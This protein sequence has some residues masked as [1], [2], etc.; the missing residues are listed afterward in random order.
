MN[1]GEKHI[2]IVSFDVP[3]PANYGGVIDVFYKVKA[4]SELGIQI[5]LHCFQYG[6]AAAEELEK[7]CC[8]VHYYKRLT[9]WHQHIASL[10]Y[11]V[12]SR[13]SIALLD[14]LQKDDYPILFEG[15]HTTFLLPHQALINREK[16][17]RMH[18]IEWRYY[19]NLFKISKNII[20]KAYYGIEAIKLRGYEK[21]IKFS[22]TTLAISPTDFKY[23]EDRFRIGISYLPAFHANENVS[24]PAGLGEYAFYH[25]NLGI[26]ENEEAALFLVNKVF[27]KISIPLVIAG[28][29][30][31]KSLKKAIVNNPN[32]SLKP[33]VSDKELFDL[34][35]GAQLNVLLAMKPSTGIKLKL[36]NVLFNG[37]HCIAN[38][39]LVDNTGLEEHCIIRNTATEIKH[40]IEHYFKRPLDD[41]AIASRK[42]DLDRDFSNKNNAKLLLEQ[43]LDF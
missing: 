32:I 28:L 8:E 31:S 25:A 30:P 21:I 19:N 17:I 43:M 18:N 42:K 33:N 14:N 29:N 10:P 9:S 26:K 15:L 35:K 34:I 40:A 11:I 24:I 27:N 1:T 13:S 39:F 36:L 16:V 5:H 4:L 6:R 38:K 12:N 37:R 3:W 2:H 23:L 22:S 20:K 41:K 7:L